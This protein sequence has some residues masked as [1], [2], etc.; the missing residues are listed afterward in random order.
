MEYASQVWDPYLQK[1][2][3]TLKRWDLSYPAMLRT[4]SIP[5]LAARRQQLKL[6]TFFRYVNQL[7]IAPIA[8]ITHRVPPFQ[9]RHI[10]DLAFV[11]PIARTNQY[12]YSFFPPYIQLISG[13][14]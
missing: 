9:S 7:S 14:I 1:D 6:C 10:H 3:Q 8:N 4:L 11:C 13:T 12:M 2:Q 5:T